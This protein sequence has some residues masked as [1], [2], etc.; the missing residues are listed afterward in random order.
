M[1]NI[2]DTTQ[3]RKIGLSPNDHHFYEWLPCEICKKGRWVLLIRHIPRAN[4][5]LP[6]SRKFTKHERKK[7]ASNYNWKGGIFNAR[8]YKYIYVDP[9]DF[10]S[11]MRSHGNYVFEHRLVMAK[12][13]NRCL[14][15]WEVVHHINGI[16]DDNRFEN[17]ELLPHKGKH[18]TMITKYL[19]KLERE[20]LLLR[21]ENKK[22]RESRDTDLF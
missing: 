13:L 16:K 8:G 2:G 14:L 15:P 20:V 12:H 7:G 5:C 3:G 10:F 6:C 17:L 18:N 22:L 9:S 4:K 11:P 1:P 21:E 19:K